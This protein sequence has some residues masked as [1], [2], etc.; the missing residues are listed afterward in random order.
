[1]KRMNILNISILSEVPELLHN[2]TQLF[3]TLN[4]DWDSDRLVAAAIA[5]FLTTQLDKES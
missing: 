2:A 4:P 5:L 3:L 1:M